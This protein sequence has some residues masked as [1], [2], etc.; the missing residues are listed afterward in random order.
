LGDSD[1]S[2]AQLT[3]ETAEAQKDEEMSKIGQYQY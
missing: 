1:G 2:M 3:I